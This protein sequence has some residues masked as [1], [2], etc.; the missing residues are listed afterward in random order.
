MKKSSTVIASE[1]E[2]PPS[3][4]RTACNR[5]FAFSG[6][7]PTTP[8]SLPN[9]LRLPKILTS[10]PSDRTA[11]FPISPIV[12]FGAHSRA[13][14]A[15]LR[16]FTEPEP[17]SIHQILLARVQ[18]QDA[19]AE[20]P[21]IE[22]SIQPYSSGMLCQKCRRVSIERFRPFLNSAVLISSRRVAATR[23]ALQS[24]TRPDLQI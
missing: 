10:V 20:I 9:S 15:F 3:V 13:A 7:P 8:W 5:A 2:A 12:W 24:R 22:S 17:K 18:V 11:L 23:Q 19:R 4:I 6:I 21:D 1:M 14:T 16:T